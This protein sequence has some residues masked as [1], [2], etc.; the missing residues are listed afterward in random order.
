VVV[1]AVSIVTLPTALLLRRFIGRPGGIGSGILLASP[2]LLPLLAALIFES[3][4]LP[5]IAVLRPASS[6]L[7]NDPGDFVY[8]LFVSDGRVLTPYTFVGHAGGWLLMFGAIA[9]S[10]MLVRRTLGEVRIRALIRRS[11]PIAGEYT[12]LA[13]ILA[14]L[15]SAAELKRPPEL[16]LLPDGISGAFAV[17]AR[18]PRILISA[19]L[20]DALEAEELE[21]IIAH[22]IAHV[23]ARDI[24]LMFTAGVL[25]DVLAWNPL[26]HVTLRRLGR[27]REIEADRRAVALTGQPLAL[28]SGLVK[29][30]QLLRGRPAAL[31]FARRRT[32]LKQRVS[33]LLALAD[34]RAVVDPV[35]RLP[36]LAAA[37]LVAVAGL[38][39]A[40]RVASED[41][42]A[43]T[44]VWGAGEDSSVRV[45]HPKDVAP[46]RLKSERGKELRPALKSPDAM[47]RYL[48]TLTTGVALRPEDLPEWV[49]RM[50]FLAREL[51]LSSDVVLGDPGRSWVGRP[52]FTG[53]GLD[54][55][56]IDLHPFKGSGGQRR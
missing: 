33:Q 9:S 34:G 54:I 41:I 39:V 3:A 35:G 47:R 26:A 55:Y 5:D 2:L 31:A 12:E 25:R 18:R 15:S 36:Y 32:G 13:T 42:G 51:G 7:L 23:E 38:Q 27:D 11:K 40:A 4:V 17:G 20:I 10:F 21:A 8:W 50:R 52:L 24:P 28:A 6:A 14:R 30:C 29:T 1:L 22:E 44:F 16:L 56:R 53:G 46:W 43:I 48:D 19:G 49:R 37:L 45:W